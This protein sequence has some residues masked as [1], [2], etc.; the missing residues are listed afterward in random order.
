MGE[1]ATD[2]PS[3][4]EVVKQVSGKG[5]KVDVITNEVTPEEKVEVKPEV[6]AEAKVEVKADEPKTEKSIAVPEVKPAED[7]TSK[8][9]E[10]S[11]REKEIRDRQRG[12]ELKEK[13]LEERAKQRQTE[14]E[15][16]IKELE[17]RLNK[18]TKGKRPMDVLTAAGYKYQDA[19]EDVLG[20]WKPR[21]DDPIDAK[22][23]PYEVKLKALEEENAKMRATVEEIEKERRQRKNQ[24]EH[25]QF[26]DAVKRKIG[27]GS[28]KYELTEKMGSEG[29]D[30][31]RETMVE[32]W[33]KNGVFPEFEDAL[34]W[35]EEH[36][37]ELNSRLLTAE[38]VKSKFPKVEV[39]TEKVPDK[40]EAVIKPVDDKPKT[41]TAAMGSGGEA[42]VDIDKLDRNEAIRV[43]ARR[44]K[45]NE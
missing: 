28:G 17:E 36:Y 2:L 23:T 42:T 16:R 14:S 44:I 43:L 15:D 41:L 39:P 5:G 13:E 31:V 38:K 24:E 4:E 18:I 12:V 10:L 34:E 27:E 37:E 26:A 22:L 40:Q 8:F 3:I 25:Q 29:I 7:V 33:Q 9:K 32:Y 6:K 19:T 11:R 1:K 21:E 35:V 45:F 30:L 20:G